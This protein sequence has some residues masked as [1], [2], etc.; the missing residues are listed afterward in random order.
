M[1]KSI[2]YTLVCLLLLA[3]PLLSA[4]SIRA[5]SAA[6]PAQS[7]WTDYGL[8]LDAAPFGQGWDTFYEDY[9][10]IALLKKDGTYFLYYSGADNYISQRDN[11]GPAH[12]E[13]GVATSADG[14]H[15]T[16]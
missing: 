3:V 7:A 12:R 2:S 13:L 4:P 14:V 11:V 15:W 1:K 6:I 16:K 10:P 5:Q 8:V 9:T